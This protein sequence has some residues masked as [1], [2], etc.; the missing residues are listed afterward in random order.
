MTEVKFSEFK[1]INTDY[2]FRGFFSKKK[3]NFKKVGNAF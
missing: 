3:M 1:N 2:A